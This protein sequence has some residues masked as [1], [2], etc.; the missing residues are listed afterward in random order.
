MTGILETETI[1]ACTDCGKNVVFSGYVNG[2]VGGSIDP[3][4]SIYCRD[5]WEKR[6][7]G[8]RMVRTL[9]R[10]MVLHALSDWPFVS[11]GGPA[12]RHSVGIRDYYE[13]RHKT[14]YRDKQGPPYH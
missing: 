2:M 14:S 12:G 13:K 8:Q 11:S 10:G 3:Q 9:R 6:P 5:C 1:R 4:E 7:E